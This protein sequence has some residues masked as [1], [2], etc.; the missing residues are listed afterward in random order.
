ME[1]ASMRCDNVL[2]W[3]FAIMICRT[4]VQ[5]DMQFKMWQTNLTWVK[6]TLTYCTNL[7]CF[8]TK[9]RWLGELVAGIAFAA[10]RII[11]LR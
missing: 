6:R 9:S 10:W 4:A 3:G 2:F 11:S 7:R 8:Q 5:A 1:L